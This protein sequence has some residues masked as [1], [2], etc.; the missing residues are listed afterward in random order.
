MQGEI[1]SRQA[2]AQQ[3]HNR[4]FALVVGLLAVAIVTTA[5]VS[6]SSR[7]AAADEPLSAQQ[8]GTS[9]ATLDPAASLVSATYVAELGSESGGSES[10]RGLL[11]LGYDAEAG[12]VSYTVQITSPLANPSIAAICQGA[13][14]QSGST[15]ATVFAGPTISGKFSG[16]L[17]EGEITAADLVGPLL[18]Q[19]LEDL[20]LLV[21]EGG[22]YATI[23]TEGIPID[24]IRGQI[25]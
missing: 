6:H 20:I 22:A 19:D 17:A 3:V 10:P 7:A 2:R 23:G 14:G 25:Q 5:G 4:R 11:R 8:Q 21:E 18:G 24:A 9:G 1:R 15:L 12:T 13:P 16:L